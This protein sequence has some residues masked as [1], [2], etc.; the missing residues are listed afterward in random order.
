MPMLDRYRKTGGFMQLL[1]LLETCGP[2]KRDRFLEIIAAEDPAWADTIRGKMLDMS[3]IYG[4]GDDT[5]AEVMGGLQDLTVAVV[6]MSAPPE[7]RVRLTN[8]LT[9]SRRRKIEDLVQITNPSPQEVTTTHMKVIE[10]VRRM[11]QD[12]FIRF[13]RF[14]PDLVV[15]PD[16]EDKL[17]RK[18]REDE[19]VTNFAL[20]G[21]NVPHHGSGNGHGREGGSPIMNLA[22]EVM[23]SRVIEL[24]TLKKKLTDMSKENAALRH[25]LS[26]ARGKLDQIKKMA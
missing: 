18:S 8:S 6:L 14:D 23:D 25:D 2:V 9:L 26:V 24:Q 4:W 15:D 16:I 17:M 11:V 20:P 5:L 21:E 22:N 1:M 19:T 10:A 12:G 13:D 7:V 3:R